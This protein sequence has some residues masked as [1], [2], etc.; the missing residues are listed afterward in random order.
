MAEMIGIDI[1]STAIRIAQVAGVDSRGMAIVTRVGIAP[2]PE[3]AMIGGRIRKPDDV[4]VALVRA[5]KEAGINRRY[6]F[7]IGIESPEVALARLA[8]PAAL[9]KDERNSAI[10]TMNKPL[11]PTFTIQDSSIATCLLDTQEINKTPMNQVSVAL[12]LRSEVEMISTIC[13]LAKATPRAIDLTGAGLL[14]SY[15]RSNPDSGE[16]GTVVSV[17]G[18]RVTVATR[19]GMHLRSLRTVAGAGSE[20]TR[21]IMQAT[22]EDFARSEDI[23]MNSRI[24]NNVRTKLESSYSIDE[25][26]SDDGKSPG[27]RAVDNSSSILVETIAQAIESDAN[28]FQTYTQGIA[29]VGGTALLRGLKDKL[30]QRVGIPVSIGRPWAEIERSRKNA[31]FFKENGK[32]DPR[33]MLSIGPA[34]GLALWREPS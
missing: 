23:K 32:V 29:L 19:E 27:E 5:F 1:G 14:R 20:I 15:T 30:S 3:G 2:V 21:A 6:G 31:L 11:S 10:R 34:V 8:L 33:L 12:A 9:K 7:V 28:N 4:S 22:G 16:V 24:D 26:F 25:S 13:A 17:G 18:T